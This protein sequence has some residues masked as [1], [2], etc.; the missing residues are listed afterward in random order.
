M[1][2]LSY[3]D[4]RP[5]DVD[6]VHA[7]ASD[8]AVVRQLG[9]WPWPADKAFTL[10]RCQPYKGDGFVWGIC[11]QDRVIGTLGVTRGTIG[12]N[13]HPAYH[14]QGIMSQVAGDAV[15][16]AFA[17]TSIDQIRG[18]TWYDNAGSARV[19]QKLGFVHWQTRFTHAKARNIP[20]LLHD[21][22]LTRMTWQRL[23]TG[24]Q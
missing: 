3:R 12:Y 17:T 23:R 2:D 4:L 16:H 7:M 9:S 18:S 20:T 8:W 5:E 10:S 21:H 24:A 13:L 14:G 6:D 22:R 19:L 15:A 1:A 11:D